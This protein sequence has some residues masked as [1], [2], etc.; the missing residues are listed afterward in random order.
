VTYSFH[1]DAVAEHLEA[2]AY[3]ETQR[4]GLGVAYLEEF[5]RVLRLV[6]EA[7]DRHPIERKPDLRRVLLR[8]FPFKILYRVR[9]GEVEVL[10]VA[11]NRRRPTYWLGRL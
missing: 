4:P 5:E 7:P 6:G 1:P 10:A 3:Y 9:G 11:H 2:V 8:R